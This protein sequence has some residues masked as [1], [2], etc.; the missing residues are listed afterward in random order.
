MGTAQG[1][2]SPAGSPRGACGDTT[3]FSP[4]APKPKDFNT[5]VGEDWLLRRSLHR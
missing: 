4:T 3:L 5:T 2:L 1:S